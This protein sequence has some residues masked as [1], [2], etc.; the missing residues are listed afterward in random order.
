[1]QTNVRLQA[2]WKALKHRI[3]VDAIRIRPS[4]LKILLEPLSQ[5]IWYLNKQERKEKES[6]KANA[7]VLIIQIE[8]SLELNNFIIR[9]SFA[10]LFVLVSLVYSI[11]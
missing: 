8:M 11:L 2:F 1:M 6:H 4:M 7:R 9:P 5:W 10:I 3:H